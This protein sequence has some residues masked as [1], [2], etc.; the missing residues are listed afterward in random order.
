MKKIKKFFKNISNFLG[1]I[2]T[3]AGVGIFVYSFLMLIYNFSIIATTYDYDVSKNPFRSLS[4]SFYEKET[5]SETIYSLSFGWQEP[6]GKEV[7]FS[8]T[9]GAIIIVAGILIIRHKKHNGQRN[10]QI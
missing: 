3:L 1:E 8:I 10:Y 4:P 9:L 7:F 2:I 6:Y 5:T